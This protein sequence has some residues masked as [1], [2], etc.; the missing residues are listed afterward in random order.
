MAYWH[1][2]PLESLPWSWTHDIDKTY[3]PSC[4][5]YCPTEHYAKMHLQKRL[6]HWPL[7]RKF[8]PVE[9]DNHKFL[10]WTGSLCF[11]QVRVDVK[12]FSPHEILVHFTSN[13]NLVIESKHEEKQ[14][15]DGFVIRTFRRR[16]EVTKDGWSL[17]NSNY[18]N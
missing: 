10:D 11:L 2:P 16:Y 3:G 8:N 5:N 17:K 18:T 13:N 7:H 1:W 12:H 15:D 4:H 9:M 6:H 14:D